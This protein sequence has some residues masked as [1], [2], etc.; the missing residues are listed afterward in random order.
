MTIIKENKS[1]NLFTVH[2]LKEPTKLP[3]F[4]V[5]QID[6]WTPW[7][8]T[9]SVSFFQNVFNRTLESHERLRAR[10]KSTQTQ[11]GVVSAAIFPWYNGKRVGGAVWL[12]FKNTNPV[13]EGYSYL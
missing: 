11:P 6:S 12:T 13:G 1:L 7:N 9:I 2:S 3:V 4:N 5:D 10:K 8:P